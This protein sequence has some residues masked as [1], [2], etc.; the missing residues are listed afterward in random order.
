MWSRRTQGCNQRQHH[1][2][3][4]PKPTPGPAFVFV[5]TLELVHK[6]LLLQ[7]VAHGETVILQMG[8]ASVL[9][10]EKDVL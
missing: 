3:P 4:S 2:N 5:N 6:L 8:F 1:V 10:A 7:G 9:V